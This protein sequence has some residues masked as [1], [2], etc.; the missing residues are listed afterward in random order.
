MISNNLTTTDQTYVLS[1]VQGKNLKDSLSLEISNR[2]NSVYS[3][4][5]RSMGVE[6]ILR[7]DLN[8]EI[9]NRTLENAALQTAITNESIL[10][11]QS[12]NTGID[13][14]VIN[15]DTAIANAILLLESRLYSI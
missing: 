2:I 3:E 6:N 8:K 12:L 7:T 5:T 11:S 13:T 9:L 10:R 1:A 15:R 4:T 14:E